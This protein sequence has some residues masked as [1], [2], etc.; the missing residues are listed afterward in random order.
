MSLKQP[1]AKLTV[2]GAVLE[3]EYLELI[4]DETNVK[5]VVIKKGDSLSIDLDKKLTPEL[6]AEGYARQISRQIQAFRKELGLTQGDEI[7]TVIITDG[8]FKKIL[9]TQN[10]F[11]SSRTNSKEIK[12]V[13]TTE[14]TFKNKI[15][16][17]IG[18]KRGT[19]AII[20]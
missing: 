5:E 11:I 18:E 19:I 12:I 9:D 6:L 14:E 4:K 3:K 8:E 17:K 13:T 15:D 10:K 16:F 20:C 2:V 7:K 1:L